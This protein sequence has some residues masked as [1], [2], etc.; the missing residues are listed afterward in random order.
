MLKRLYRLFTKVFWTTAVSLIITAAVVVS[1]GRLLLPGIDEYREQIQEWVSGYMGQPVRIREISADW[2]GWTPNLYLTDISIIDRNRGRILTRFKRASLSIDLIASL[3]LRRPVPGRL[4]VSGIDLSLVRDAQGRVT[5]EGV[6]SVDDRQAASNRNVLVYWLQRQGNLNIS[7][8]R[9]TWN[10]QLL[11]RPPLVLENLSFQIRS[12]GDRRQLRGAATLSEK[13]G[14]AIYFALDAVGDLLTPNW[15]GQLY[16]E[17]RDVNPEILLYPFRKLGLSFN[18]GKLH[19]RSWSHWESARMTRI[20]GDFSAADIAI[21]AH[22]DQLTVQSAS[23]RFN[24]RRYGRSGWLFHTED[25][26][27]LTSN[28]VWPGSELNLAIDDIHE[29]QPRFMLQASFIR[30]EDLSTLMQS[31]QGVPAHTRLLLRE[32]QPHGD[33]H[34]LTL[35]IYPDRPAA[36]RFYLST[37]VSDLRISATDG[38]PGVSGLRGHVFTTPDAGLLNLDSKYA[39]LD[40]PSAFGEEIILGKL[41]GDITWQRHADEWHISLPEVTA[42]SQELDLRVGGHV[43]WRP[44]ESPRLDLLAELR[45]FSLQNL[46]HVLPTRLLTQTGREWLNGAISGGRVTSAG[47]VFRGPLDQFPFDRQQGRFTVQANIEG[48]ILD[49]HK[50]WPRID[51]IDARVDYH[52]HGLSVHASNARILDARIHDT[53]VTLPRLH[54]PE[55]VKVDGRI[56]FHARTGLDFIAN[57]PLREGIGKRLRDLSLDGELQLGLMLGIPLT[58]G[59]VSLDGHL[60]LLDNTLTSKQLGIRIEQLDGQL[61]FGNKTFEA[62]GIKGRFRGAPITLDLSSN[63]PVDKAGTDIRLRGKAS[64]GYI[65]SLL[66]ELTPEKSG[67]LES[68]GL[69]QRMRGRTRWQA[70]LELPPGGASE[71]SRLSIRSDLRGLALE[72]PAPLGKTAGERRNLSIDTLL[73]PGQRQ[74]LRFAYGDIISG[75]LL[76]RRNAGERRLLSTH[77]LLG[78]GRMPEHDKSG[79]WL[80]GQLQQLDLGQWVE[81]LRDSLPGETG[82]MDTG[83]PHSRIDLKVGKLM[84]YQQQFDEVSLQGG[85]SAKDWHLRVTSRDADGRIS[86]PRGSPDRPV[87]LDFQR[88]RFRSVSSEGP[89]RP[90]DPGA[91]PALDIR[92]RKFLFDDYDLGE[93][94][95]RTRPGND[96]LKLETLSFHSPLTRIDAHGKWRKQG[97]RHRSDFNI[98]VTSGKLRNLL[99]QFGYSD[100]A[101]KGGDTQLDINAGWDGA[102]TDFSLARL[103]GTLR[104]AV[105][106]GRILDIDPKAGRLFALLSFQTLTRRLSLDFSDLFKKGFSFDSIQG[107]FSIENGEAYT[108]NLTMKGSSA[109]I[110]VTGRVGLKEQDYDQLVT[111]TPAFASSLPVASALLGPIGAG[112]GAVVLA[113]EKLFKSLPRTIDRILRTQYSVTGSWDAPVIRKLGK[114]EAPSQGEDE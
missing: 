94:V 61:R 70:S 51:D 85:N 31:L 42:R 114:Q 59:P 109:R 32:L 60:H 56:D 67:W 8:A 13:S 40:I 98:H 88:L 80:G 64:S 113:A 84:L 58:G 79:F 55:I 33:L 41:R 97:P 23:G 66:N 26:R 68:S 110:E 106:P 54:L 29:R 11:Q 43:D 92:C 87:K 102:P 65:I 46:P 6:N 5:I 74:E 17:G 49:F 25:L 20:D 78:G 73:S 27:L 107:S 105:G 99:R 75:H 101:I 39:G 47:M 50:D 93:M 14:K 38:F 96:G 35:G 86:L 95:M 12:Q 28:G 10:D 112:V 30:L 111:V 18:T 44:G 19:F 103:T 77:I 48:G 37:Q 15:S 69:F 89:G 63:G 3:R 91:I 2:R 104:I 7:S 34:Q 72:L 83:L 16:L 62:E 1:I 22:P 45:N 81:L 9:V 36:Q 76:L 82:G 90:F 52:G 21:G 4:Q 53:R 57:S 71:A 24:A 108:N 100:A